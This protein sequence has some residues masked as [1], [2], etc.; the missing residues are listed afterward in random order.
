MSFS[1]QS[2]AA[3]RPAQVCESLFG[4]LGYIDDYLV[5][6]DNDQPGCPANCDCVG[7]LD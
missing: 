6:T 3:L 5:A 1:P 7:R 4:C 2:L